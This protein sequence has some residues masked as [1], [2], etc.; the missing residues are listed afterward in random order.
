[1]PGDFGTDGL[2]FGDGIDVAVGIVGGGN[3]GDVATGGIVL[4]GDAVQASEL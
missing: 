2:G 3:Q 1:M 4:L